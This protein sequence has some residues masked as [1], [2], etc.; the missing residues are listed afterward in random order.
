[1]HGGWQGSTCQSPVQQR[2][3]VLDMQQLK[4]G[5]RT[6]QQPVT[7]LPVP[8][9]SFKSALAGL[10]AVPLKCWSP[11]PNQLLPPC[12]AHGVSLDK[13]TPGCTVTAVLVRCAHPG[14]LQ[15]WA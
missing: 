9:C 15:P 4:Q 6:F 14:W 7:L 3:W 2:V 8:N 11:V 12:A 5:R 13:H 10:P 1:M